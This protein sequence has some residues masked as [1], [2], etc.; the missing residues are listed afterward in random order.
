MTPYL[1]KFN[2]EKT[3]ARFSSILASSGTRDALAFL[4]GLTEYRFIG[5]FRFQDGKAKAVVHYDCENPSVKFI[6]EVPDTATYCCY[7]RDSKQV[8]TTANAMSDQRLV[9]HPAREE[10]LA[11]TGLPIMSPEGLVL[12]TLCHYDVVPRDPNQLDIELLLQVVSALQQ[13]KHV[14]SYS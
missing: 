6:S 3:F 7:V 13:G 12:G 10:V 2:T 8:F 14:P 5:I 11:Y 4:V 9:D 1:H